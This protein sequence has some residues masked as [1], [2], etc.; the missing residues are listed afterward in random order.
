M[1]GQ[2]A[3][4]EVPPFAQVA[5][6]L[7]CPRCGSHLR[8]GNTDLHGLCGPCRAT[9]E[10][11][12]PFADKSDGPL[13][14]LRG[15]APDGVNVLEL[16]AGLLL[17]HD[18][19]HRGEPLYL[20]E[21]LAA[22]GVELDHIG[23]NKVVNKLRRRHGFVVRGEPREPGYAVEDWTYEARRVRSSLGDG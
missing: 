4:C 19:L 14:A 6:C 18:A 7:T 21:A 10:S 3:A 16:A 11:C 13:P 5:D 1:V 17:T 9:V 23:V 12:V 8:D 15:P 22:Y 2:P 20:R